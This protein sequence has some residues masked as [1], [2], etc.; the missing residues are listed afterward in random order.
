VSGRWTAFIGLAYLGLFM[1]YFGVLGVLLPQQVAT[2]V[3]QSEKVI[4]FGWVSGLGAL[5]GAISNPVAG[6]LSDRTSTAFGRRLPWITGGA[7]AGGGALVVL[8]MERSIVGIAVWWCL[9]Q[10]SL[11]CMQAGIAA[12]VPDQVPV[13]QRG[14]VS[15]WIGVPQTLS[16]VVSIAL[17]T[18]IT[19]GR[20]GYW[21]LAAVVVALAAPFIV[22]TD[23]SVVGMTRPSVSAHWRDREMLWSSLAVADFRWV[24]LTRFGMMLG[25]A[26]GVVY[27][28]YF[29]DSLM[30]SHVISSSMSV[31]NRLI[32]LLAIYVCGVSA[33]AAIAGKLSDRFGRRRAPVAVSGMIAAFPALALA[34]WP[35]W[36]VLVA[37]AL[38]LGMGYGVYL[39]VDQALVTL[40]LPS[41]TGIARDLGILNIASAGAQAMAPAI[42]AVA[43]KAGGYQ[44]LYL[45]VAALIAGSSIA[46][47]KIRSVR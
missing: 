41:A 7:L 39:A 30:R 44:S 46:V 2:V 27:L 47:L 3:G 24:W 40:V 42:A 20:T 33:T 4:A 34:L 18:T 11:N 10:I 28:L 15:S 1:A 26:M 16:I 8:S 17:V 25:N 29:L 23:D 37:G 43:V 32:L 22:S 5:C 19:H 31:D 13:S 35:R 12:C 36:P 14:W 21:L 38:V 9:A 45:V 6:A